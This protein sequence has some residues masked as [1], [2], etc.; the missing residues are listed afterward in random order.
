MV[1]DLSGLSPGSSLLNIHLEILI[2]L[3][4]LKENAMKKLTNA[5]MFILFAVV[6]IAALAETRTVTLAVSGMT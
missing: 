3:F 1:C 4:L 2:A 5:A 6:S